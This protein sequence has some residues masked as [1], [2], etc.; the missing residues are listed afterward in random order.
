MFIRSDNGPEFVSQTLLAWVATT[1][2][3]TVLINPG[4]HWRCGT[5][6]SF[7]RKISRRVSVSRACYER[8]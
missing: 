5:D 8:V 2:I 6:E 4:K 7:K 3:T 1:A